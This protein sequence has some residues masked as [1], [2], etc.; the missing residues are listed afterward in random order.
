MLPS[1][2]TYA[3]LQTKHRL[4]LSGTPVQNNLIEFWSL[5]DFVY[6]GRLGDLP[7]FREVFEVPIRAGAAKSATNMAVRAAKECTEVLR[8]QIGP[9]MLRRTKHNVLAS[10]PS[11]KEQ[12]LA[13]DL[14]EEQ[15]EKYRAYLNGTEMESVIRGELPGLAGIDALRKICNH[16]DLRNRKTLQEVG[17]LTSRRS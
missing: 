6:P 15:E 8:E 1:I 14:T 9:Y 3:S 7:T 2:F 13:C 12:V 11:K 5:F 16:P 4:I 17:Y 10:L